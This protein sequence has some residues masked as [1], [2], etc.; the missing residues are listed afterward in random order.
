MN[1]RHYKVIFS[2]VLN[3][4][5]VVSEL[6]KSQGKAQSENMSSVQAKTGLFST[7][8]SL[9][10]IHFSLMLA[11]G[12]VFLSPSVQAE[13]MAIR[14]DKS[15]PGNQQPTVLQT[16]NGIPQVNIQAPSQAG[17]SRNQYSQ[18][19]VAEKG[20][21]LN[22]ARKAYQTQMA[23]WVQGNPN[24]ARGEAKVILNEVNSANPSR[25]KGY[26]EVAGK[27]A[28]VVIANPS[29]I[30]CDGCGVINAGRTTLTT[31][32]AEVENGE[33]KGYRVKGG[34][35]TVGQKGMDNSQSD[36]TDIIAEKAEIKGGVWSKKGIKVTTG[37]N[38][39]DRTNDSVVYVG[40]KNSDKAESTSNTQGENQ[41]YSVDVGQLGGMYAE[42]IHLVDN[43]Q[44]LGVRN[45]GHIGAA[46][47]DVKIDSQGK[48]VNS[49][50]ISSTQQAELRAKKTIENTGKIETKQGNVSLRSQANVAQHGSIVSRQGGISVQAK[51]NLTQTGET[52]V[53]GN[54]TY[55]AKNIEASKGALIAAGV[56]AQE[57]TKGE[58]RS[59][60]SQSA[61]GASIMLSAENSVSSKAQ[62]LASGQINAKAGTLD[63]S[64]S[65]STADSIALQSTYS[66]LNLKQATLYSEGN[67]TLIS[68]DAILAENTNLNAGHFV[69]DTAQLNNK[70]SSWIQRGKEAFS[71][72]LK[73]GL[74]NTQGKIAAE[75]LISIQSPLIQ[76]NQGVIWSNQGVKLNTNAGH[77]ESQSGYLFGKNSLDISTSTLNNQKGEMLGGQVLLTAQ[78]VNNED[79]KLIAGNR[80]DLSVNQFNNQRGIV[81]SQGELSLK[82]ENLHNQDGIISSVSRATLLANDL[83][84]LKGVIQGESDLTIQTQNLNNTQGDISAK[85]AAISSAAINNAQGVISSQDLTLSGTNLNNKGGIVQSVN[86]T[87]NLTTMD[88]EA[89]GD[90]GSLVSATNRLVLNVTNVNNK[91]TKAKQDTPTQGIQTA[92]LVMNADHVENQSGGIYVGKSANLTINQSLDNQKG[93][94]LSTGRVDIVNPDLTLVVNNALGTI[95]SVIGT[96]L[97][98]KTLV[99]EGSIITKGDLGIELNDSFTLNKAFGVGNNL[100]FKTKGD[101]VNNSNLVV[102][103]SASVEGST[104]QNNANAEISSINTRIQTNKL[105]NFGLIDGDTTVIKANDVNNIGTARIYG[106]HLAIQANNLNNLENADGTAATIAA[107]ERLDL[108]VGNLVNRNHSLIMSLGN[109]YIG[110]QLNENNQATGYANS[111]DNGSAT[112]EA[113][114]SGWI[115]THHLLNQDLHLKLG[116]KVEKEQINEYSLGSD[117]HRYRGGVDGY[118][119]LNNGS[120]NPNSYF[121]LNNGTRIEGFGWKEWRYTRTTTTSTIEHQDPAKI[122][123]GGELH[124]SGEDLNNKQSQIFVGQKLLLDDK[125]F[126]QSTNERLSGAISKLDNDDIHGTIDITDEGQFVQEYKVRRKR[127][128]KGHHHYH[129]YSDFTDVHPTQDFSFGLKLLTIAEPVEK[130]GAT[131]DGKSDFQGVSVAEKTPL[132]TDLNAHRVNLDSITS[133]VVKNKDD[134]GIKTH[135]PN[136][137]LP[138]ASLYKIN[139]AASGQFLV[140]TDPRFTQRSK[141]LS[142]DYMFKQIHN[143]PKNI[144]KRLGDGFYEQR[145]VNEQINQLTGRRFLHGYSS[146]YE[147]YKALMDNGA[148]YATKLN[149]IPGVAL[150]A[151]QMKQL[152]SDMVWMVKR[153]VTLKDGTKTEVLVPQVYIVGRNA[154]ID[155]RGAV[156]SANDVIID[157]QGDVKNSGVISGRNLTHLSANNIEN[158]GGTLQGRDLYMLAKNRINNLGG[159]LNAT[160]NLVGIA[161]TINIESSLS[162]TADNERFK[163]KSIN[164]VA[165]I[166]VGAKNNQGQVSLHAKEDMTFK[167]AKVDVKGQAN[168][169]ANNKLSLGTVETENKQH[170]IKNS[171]NYYKLEQR[172]E[173]GSEFNI[174][175]DA[176]FVGKNAIEMR[177]ASAVSNGTMSVLS[178]GDINI[179][180]SRQQERLSE[181]TKWTKHGVFQ[182]KGETRRHNHNYDIA[183]GSTL[184]ADKIYIHSNNGNVDIQGSNAVAENGLVIKANNID[185]H[186][187]ENRVYSDDYY[188]K[189]R[190]GALSGGIGITFGS[191]KQTTESDQTKLYAQGSQVGSLNGNTTMIAEN[192]YTQTA[193]KVSA[194]KD[195]D[196]NI[197]AKKVD[198]KAADDKYETNTKQKFEQKGLTIAITSPV[199]SAVQAVQGAVQSTRQ[200]GESKHGRVNAMAAANAGFDAYR[201]ADSVMKAGDSI[202]KAMSNS[203]VDS[204]VGVQ[205]TYGQ[206]KSESSTHTEGKTAAKSQ[207][208]AGG[209]VNI[210]ATG[211]GKASNI[212]IQGS[213]VSGK[214]GTFLEADNDI[215]IT[216]AEQT[217]KER[218]TN[219]SSGFN[220]GVAMK[221]S[222]GTAVGATLGGNYGKGYGNGD[223]TTYVAS[224]VGDSQSKTVIQAGGDANLIGSQVKGKRVEVN[225]QNLNIESLQDTATYKGKQMNGSGSVTVGYGASVGGSFNKSNIHA[226]HASVNEQAGIYAGDE[227]YDINVNHTDLKGGLITSTQ[228]AEDEGKNRFSTGTIT[229]S[230]IE[231]HSNYSG[232][233]FGVSGSVAANFDTPFGKEGQAQSSKQAVDD[234]GNPIYR[235][236]RGELTTEAKNAQGKDNAKQLATGWDSLETSTGF[237]IGRDKESQSSV[238]KSGINTAN[239]EIRDQAEQLAKTGE[240]VEQTLDSIKTD[241]T[242]DNAE[243]HSGKLENHFDKDKVM[244]ELNIQVKVTQDFRKNAF[245][246]I[247]DY[248]LP[249]QAELRK[250]IKEAKTEEEKTAL[251]GAIYKLQYQKRLLETVVG[252]AA[253]SPDVAI[254]QGTL[255]LAATKMREETL[256]NSRLFKGIKDAKTGKILRNDSYDSGYF[257]G[258]KLG[259][260]RIDVDAICNSNMGTCTYN[261]DNSITFKGNKDYTLDDAIDP[262]Q[263]KKAGGLYGETGGFQPVQGEWNLHFKR[264]PYSIGSISDMAVESFAGTHDL[265]GGQAWGWYDKQGNTAEKNKLTGV[266]SGVTTVIAI[267]VSAPFAL[268]DVM[269]SDM[270]ELLMKI[271]GK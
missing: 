2:R 209:K 94:I 188:S 63:L 107:R 249:K 256:A 128:R 18:F 79:G 24:L 179:H 168:F 176:R 224:H 236:D 124:L 8:L 207:V 189:K 232:S 225:A 116:K 55:Q 161:K 143:D 262:Q 190:S 108:G 9:N 187:A 111:I 117:S 21:V 61:Q 218:S 198:I 137:S 155:S 82:T 183:E 67:T 160:N 219:K 145:L 32:K 177:G 112:I 12:F 164:R 239:I 191:Q 220:A 101:F 16:G 186:E 243:Q 96:T 73:K 206:Q 64:E 99:D 6:V 245:S 105:N 81:Y 201:A 147:Q 200:V 22:N 265:L 270:F 110:G 45:A 172:N 255:Q 53:K 248:V 109:I 60:D 178:E 65:Q 185:I 244:K 90:K 184:D 259:G 71:L 140:E 166:N 97:Q 93:E 268:S 68:P 199:I 70:K 144:L 266:A 72:N 213:D 104:I 78:Q 254:T 121:Q 264:I 5:V 115:K 129:N 52:V 126:T 150:T 33:L 216:A 136:I 173:V 193:S 4:L 263:N 83:N 27:K 169:H 246:M 39:I 134:L 170:Y 38:N 204:V 180:E 120:R 257:D 85:T 89:E 205:I 223:E 131:V 98:A 154:D 192:T 153:E 95:E 50:T 226:D 57:T 29:G 119:N 215:N 19:D 221:V 35:V 214:Q 40:D 138:Q 227:G 11:L 167:G 91:N 103:N 212:T 44:G 229:H 76:N 17:V 174:E 84:N 30:Q 133:G 267:P 135:L 181:A 222:N 66:P 51:D 260:V 252:I 114:G 100:T 54:V 231:N 69:I 151:E 43:G 13:D 102:G 269:S 237:G 228:K 152:T 10:P 7:A 123:I 230:D 234:D 130:T 196:V 251:Y 195:G 92:N 175:G 31:G 157:T 34:K 48:V 80:A 182:S 210:V 202:Q 217:H 238:T 149:L 59:L 142:S 271:G 37:K 47:G 211:A 156:I 125:V 194:I 148:Q 158:T 28:D 41:G 14:A 77:I 162:E 258:V 208:N 203:D 74:D 250:Q 141:W 1:K 106:G 15:A 86:S 46:A 132:N 240:T 56:T 159:A 122:L 233:S 75:G 23:G 197:L 25:L 163:H 235:N 139:P 165:S 26:V 242:T 261:D 171:N 127:G 3:Q 118:Y 241:V 36:Y 42:K 253:G 49:G 58:T 113:L 247:D 88:N 146:D 62:H 87:L 20:A